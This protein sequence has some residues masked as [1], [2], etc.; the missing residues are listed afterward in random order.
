MAVGIVAML[1]MGMLVVAAGIVGFLLVSTSKPVDYS[2]DPD[3]VAFQ[4]SLKN[5]SSDSETF[6]DL[7]DTGSDAGSPVDSDNSSGPVYTPPKA[8]C[9]DGESRCTDGAKIEVCK[10]KVWTVNETCGANFECQQSGAGYSCVKIG[11]FADCKFPTAK[12]GSKMCAAYDDIN[13]APR[14]VWKCDDGKWVNPEN[15]TSASRCNS[16]VCS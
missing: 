13:V 16:G 3:L 14:Y 7:P 1:F 2:Q 11:G 9:A 10:Y 6:S 5:K 4:E 12:H 8:E 15:C